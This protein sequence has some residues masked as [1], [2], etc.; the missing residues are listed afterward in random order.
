MI[1]PVSSAPEPPPA[2]TRPRRHRLVNC[3]ELC[4]TVTL[5]GHLDSGSNQ[6]M[7]TVSLR[8]ADGSHTNTARLVWPLNPGQWGRWDWVSHDH[9]NNVSYGDWFGV[10]IQYN[11]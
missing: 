9:D 10:Q 7:V 11:P 1:V 4:E 8:T 3:D 6:A 5:D 2:T